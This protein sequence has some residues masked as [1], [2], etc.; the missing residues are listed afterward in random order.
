MTERSGD[1]NRPWRAYQEEVE[2][3]WVAQGPA[4][5]H[6]HDLYVHVLKQ[7]GLAVKSP[8]DM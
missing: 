6:R 2:T 7:F 5:W 8:P 3:P 4:E 1:D